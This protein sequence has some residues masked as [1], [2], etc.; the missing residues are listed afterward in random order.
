MDDPKRVVI[1]YDKDGWPTIYADAGTDVYSVD[2]R[3]PADRIYRN[4]PQQIPDGMLDGP[5]GYLG[6]KSAAEVRAHRAA[7]YIEGRP[8]LTLAT[9]ED[10][11]D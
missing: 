6:D 3:V 7:A 11:N 8:H 9:T 2:E 4:S 10:S 1:Y 5:V